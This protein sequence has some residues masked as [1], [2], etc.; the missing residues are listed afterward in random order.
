MTLEQLQSENCSPSHWK[1]NKE[2]ALPVD[3]RTDLTEVL[4]LWLLLDL[5]RNFKGLN[6]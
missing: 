6:R 3:N 5:K 1:N 4:Y 2:T